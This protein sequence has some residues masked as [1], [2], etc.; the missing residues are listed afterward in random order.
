MRRRLRHRVERRQ[1]I[2]L[3]QGAAYGINDAWQASGF[4]N[5]RRL[6]GRNRLTLGAKV[7]YYRRF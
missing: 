2:N 5:R 7:L 6:Q 4:I 1:V 3:G